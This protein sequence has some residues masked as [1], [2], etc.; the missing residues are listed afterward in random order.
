VG[1]NSLPISN[2]LTSLQ[3]KPTQPSPHCH[4]SA[5]GP[6][7]PP[8]LSGR[9]LIASSVSYLPTG[10]PQS[11]AL[12]IPLLRKPPQHPLH[13]LGYPFVI[14]SAPS[15]TP[16]LL[17]VFLESHGLSFFWAI[18][19]RLTPFF[20]RGATEARSGIR[21]AISVA[22]RTQRENGAGVLSP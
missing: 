15:P 3:K 19:V 2:K 21:T 7:L 8:S 9:T 6:F 18:P 1:F 4:Y 14:F 13:I 22:I 20:L 16:T 12:F 17:R 11:K 5:S 10:T